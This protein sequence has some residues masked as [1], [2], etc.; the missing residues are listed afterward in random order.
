MKMSTDVIGL[1]ILGVAVGLFIAYRVPRYVRWRK[2]EV[3]A[4]R[5]HAEERAKKAVAV[6]QEDERKARLRERDDEVD[7]IL[8]E[9]LLAKMD[10][11]RLV[12]TIEDGDASPDSSTQLRD[13]CSRHER[14]MDF[15]VFRKVAEYFP[16]P[17]E[18]ESV[19]LKDEIDVLLDEHCDAQTCLGYADEKLGIQRGYEYWDGIKG[20]GVNCERADGRYE[21]VNVRFYRILRKVTGGDQRARQSGP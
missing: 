13:W 16:K 5:R 4:E 11:K 15:D 19:L 6:R 14:V 8:Q 7:H 10:L 20:G 9:L 17:D 12:A 2:R 3:A 18:N 21:D 1:T